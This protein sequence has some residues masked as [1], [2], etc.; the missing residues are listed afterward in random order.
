VTLL[1]ALTALGAPL[2]DACAAA[3]PFRLLV[4]WLPAVVGTLLAARFEHRFGA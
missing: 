2:A 4:F 3:L 1:L